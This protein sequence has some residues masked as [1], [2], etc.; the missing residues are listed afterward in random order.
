[1]HRI[2]FLIV[3]PLGACCAGWAQWQEQ[4]TGVDVQLRGISAVS[5]TVAWASGANGTILRTLNGGK[6]WTRLT[7]EGAEKLDF[8]NIRAF[9]DKTAYALSIGP[10]EQS[11][12][13]KTTDGGQRWQ[14][15]FT[16]HDPR[17][18]YDCFAFWDPGHGIAVSD[19]VDGKFPLLITGDGST[20][21]A[22]V[23]DKIPPA[24]PDEGAFA[25]SGTCI[26]TYGKTDVWF[27]TGGPAAR[28]FHSSDRGLH[29]TVAATPILSGA[30]SQGIFSIAFSSAQDGM[31]VGG[32]YMH[33]ESAGKNAAYTQ[34]GG[35]T[36]TL[37]HRLPGGYRS[38][39]AIARVPA[40]NCSPM[41]VLLFVATGTNGTDISMDSGKNWSRQSSGESNAVSFAGDSGWAV[42]PHGHIQWVKIQ[43]PPAP[44]SELEAV[45]AAMDQSSTHF[46]TAQADF[47]WDNYQ[48]VVDETEKQSGK[49]Y[50]C[51]SGNG[52]AGVEAMFEIAS[53][54]AKKVL[55]KSG[56][57]QLYNAR[58]DQITEY[59]PGKNKADVDA[60]LS[61]GF[62]APG[63]DLLCS[64]D[65]Q[66]AGWETLDGVKRPNSSSPHC[67]K[68]YEICSANSFC[69]SIPS[70]MFR[71]GSR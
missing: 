1:M 15:Q 57:I 51:R 21:T 64:Y 25:A 4:K 63:H 13:Y 23:P 28:V 30:P 47:E 19:S 41:D 59:K 44:A 39:A 5:K 36:W 50:F 49:V 9:D 10:G 71:S 55:F 37:S 11:R 60:Y 43:S 48:K 16:N 53:P 65:V 12:I 2:F 45:L 69:G 17:A 29:W 34:D 54:A 42:G 27:A 58:M 14:L 26:A 24:L 38:G 62:G 32:D 31:I 33:P 7:V 6:N 20:W 8:R 67:R 52:C 22:L 56:E 18:F 35:R 68:M 66:M 61:L 46:T 3:L 70:A 40:G